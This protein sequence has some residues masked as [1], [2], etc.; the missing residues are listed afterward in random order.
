MFGENS[1]EFTFAAQRVR[2]VFRHRVIV[3]PQ[4]VEEANDEL[5]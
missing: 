4:E 5:H 3:G 1:C 2:D